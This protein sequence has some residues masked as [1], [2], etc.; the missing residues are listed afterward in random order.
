[1]I[2][3]AADEFSIDLP[4]SMLVGDKAT[5]IEAAVAAGVGTKELVA[6]PP[7]GVQAL[8]AR[9]SARGYHG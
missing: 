6:H 2:L 4:A 3:A 5:D 7:G 9:M 1:M 8:L